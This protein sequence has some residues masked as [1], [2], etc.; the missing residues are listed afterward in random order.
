MTGVVTAEMTAGLLGYLGG[1]AVEGIIVFQVAVLLIVLSN[2][3]VW[4]K[5]RPRPGA[6]HAAD[7]E[8]LVS[9][10]VPCRNEE[11]N[12]HAC[13]RALLAQTYGHLEILVLDDQSEDGTRRILEEERTADARL[14]VLQGEP[15]PDGWTG[16]NW[17]CHQLAQAARGDVL[18]FVDA[19]TVLAPEAVE[20]MVATLEAEHAD[21]LSGLPRQVLGSVGERLLVPIFCWAVFSFTPLVTGYLWPRAA[22]PTAVGQ[23][24]VFRRGAYSASGGHAG[25]RGS[26]VDDLALARRVRRAG[27]AARMIDA[28]TLASCRMYRGGRDAYRGFRKNLFGAFGYA[29]FPYAFVWLWLA[30]VYLEPLAVL[31]VCLLAPDRASAPPGL[32]AVTIALSL[33]QWVF[34]YARLRL[35]LWPAILYP[36]S[37][38]GFEAMAMGSFVSGVRRKTAWR[39]R[40][41]DRPRIRLL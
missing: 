21:F 31:A 1:G 4:H 23:L 16:K 29:V 36:L 13:V 34:V 33:A 6:G 2:S 32:L 30:W 28:G 7:A 15:L 22:I 11:A 39:G 41:V 25:I 27:L 9:L 12:V 18:F 3:W 20:R 8:P 38:L 24:M 26:I 35:P 37:V 10:L 17:A 19:D 14:G 5:L 40:N